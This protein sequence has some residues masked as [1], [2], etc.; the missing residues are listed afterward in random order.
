MKSNRVSGFD[1]VYRYA[2]LALVCLVVSAPGSV[3]QD[4]LAALKGM[5]NGFV[6]VIE[7][8]SPA[9][10][11]VRV[12]QV[13]ERARGMSP[14][15]F[16][17]DG[18]E[19]FE[20]FFG[21]R[22]GMRPQQQAPS[23]KE[24]VEG[25]GS[26]FIISKEGYILTNNHVVGN[27]D[28][29]FVSLADQ[30]EYEAKVI[31]ADPESD[32]ALIK[33][34]SKDE[35]PFLPLGSS[36]DAK[37][38]QFVIAIGNPFRLSHSVTTGIISAKGRSN[39]GITDYDDLIQ[40]DAAINP[41]NSGGPLI[42]LQ[43]EVIGINTAIFSRSGGYMGIGFAIPIDMAK[44]IMDQLKE[45]GTVTR[46]FIG[47][48]IQDI[49][50]QM[51][52]SLELSNPDGILVSDVEKDSPAEKAGLKPG[53]IITHLNGQEVNRSAAFRNEVALMAPETV[54]KLTIVRDRKEQAIDLKLGKKDDYVT[55]VTSSGEKISQSL[56][57]TVQS[58]SEDLAN[59]LGYEGE[60][61]VIVT[62]VDPESNA[63]RAGIQPGMLIKEINREPVESLNDFNALAQKA[64]E[65]GTV[66][67]LVKANERT[68]FIPFDL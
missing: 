35:L 21:Q 15:E 22:P 58:L 19:L 68:Y 18:N 20:R 37:V 16:F 7:K 57:F 56:G 62:E 51:A 28:K 27:A 10:V 8:A 36:S 6:Q 48:F 40:T 34:D 11:N 23:R 13:V 3:A 50:P 67:L 64:V 47:I 46:G 30:R 4:D 29:V 60:K 25:E 26:G 14:F 38:G 24:R 59:K 39:I 54:I 2:F 43:G 55:S 1:S 63:F 61:G 45:T 33:I 32:V 9:V 52:K 5:Q 17:G 41:G 12:E 49:T 66:I 53:D 44:K 31:G 42:N 65:K